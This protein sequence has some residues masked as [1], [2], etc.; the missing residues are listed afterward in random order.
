METVKNHLVDDED[1]YVVY[2]GDDTP[3]VIKPSDRKVE[4]GKKSNFKTTNG[5][6]ILHHFNDL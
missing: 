5:P 2:L 6:Y 3:I 1:D 4:S